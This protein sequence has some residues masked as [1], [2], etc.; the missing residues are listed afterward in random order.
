MSIISWM[1]TA[2]CV[3]WDTD[4]FFEKYLED[5]EAATDVTKLCLMCPVQKECLNFGRYMKSSGVWGGHWLQ[6]GRVVNNREIILS[7]YYW[8]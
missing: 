4:L 5:D 7:D 2:S 8:E 3:G 6:N 1:D